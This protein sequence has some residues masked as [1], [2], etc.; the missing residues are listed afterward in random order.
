MGKKSREKKLRRMQVDYNEETC[1][2]DVIINEVSKTNECSEKLPEKKEE[3]TNL[4]ER[5]IEGFYLQKNL[6][7]LKHLGWDKNGLI[8]KIKAAPNTIVKIDPDIML[9]GMNN[10]LS[11]C[12]V[13]FSTRK[14]YDALMRK[15]KHVKFLLIVEPNISAFKHLISVEDIT[16]ILLRKDTEFII[17]VSG[18]ALLPEVFR[19]F[20]KPLEKMMVSRST[21][22]QN[23]Q[24]VLDPFQYN[25]D[26]LKKLGGGYVETIKDTIDQLKL[27]LGCSDD[28]FRRYELLMENKENMF[29]SWNM[30]GL[31]DK[32]KNV[33][34]IVLGGGPSLEGFLEEFKNNKNLANAL[35][36][37]ADAVL[38][39]L[40]TAGVKPHLVVRCE[41]KLTNIFKGITK[42]M[43]KGV[44]YCAYPWTPPEFFDLFEDSFYL[45]R[46]NGVCLFSEMS[47]VNC[48]GGVSSG[49]AALEL[50][51]NLG[52]KDIIMSGIDLCFI[53]GKTH[54]DGTQ[55]EF[56]VEHSKAKWFDIQTNDGKTATTIPV[57]ERCRNEYMQSIDKWQRK[58]KTFTVYNTSLQGAIIPLTKVAKWGEISN[59]FICSV[60]IQ[61]LIERHRTKISQE[62][63]DKFK[64]KIKNTIVK[65]QEYLA[66]TKI[67]I[68]LAEDAKRTA[69][70]ELQKLVNHVIET[71]QNPY[72]IVRQI[73]HNLPNYEKLWSHVSDAY[74]QNFKNKLY[75]EHLFR[76]LV[77]DVLQ[78]D[79]Y[80][81]ENA[82]SALANTVNDPD[83]R[84]YGYYHLTKEFALKVK[85]Y[86]EMFLELFNKHV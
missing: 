42:E 76:I 35:I 39:R 23:I 8:D 38:H 67:A 1:Q 69:D 64:T 65:V 60:N 54:V 86:L 58:G 9:S 55:V 85:Y 25:T 80:H 19:S 37:C 12:F 46:Q 2:T 62:E 16:D 52:A 26:E 10:P 45:F 32:F 34:V 50:A 82:I 73:R 7:A 68:G 78:L 74:D 43:T 83:E 4:I 13:G 59:K 27:S 49:N 81:V 17:G 5:P 71:N 47:H 75:V 51:I 15:K 28:Q 40:L 33:P 24:I 11:T 57:W 30:R 70:R 72:E 21:T 14:L 56:N 29:K 36:I 53:D 48:D 41:R 22:I 77:F 44:H 6:E 61:E 63:I 18:E 31:Y 66:Q 79:L 3:E 84:H 20:T